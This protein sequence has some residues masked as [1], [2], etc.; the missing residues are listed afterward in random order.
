MNLQMRHFKG[1]RTQE[2][3]RPSCQQLCPTKMEAVIVA[4]D[5]SCRILKTADD[6]SQYKARAIDLNLHHL[7]I[8]L[9]YNTSHIFIWWWKYMSCIIIATPNL[10]Y[11]LFCTMRSRGR[12][13]GQAGGGWDSL[14]SACWGWVPLPTLWT[15][16]PTSPPP[17]TTPSPP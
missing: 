15:S 8:S 9:S 2:L 11:L 4:P 17:P 10:P 5:F 13:S 1:Q 12:I 6:G 7:L 16:P 14:L 3:I